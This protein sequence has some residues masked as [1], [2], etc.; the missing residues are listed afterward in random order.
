MKNSPLFEKYRGPGAADWLVT[1]A[2]SALIATEIQTQGA[3]QRAQSGA[4]YY[5]E[6]P[7]VPQLHVG[8]LVIDGLMIA[9]A[10]VWLL[11]PTRK[12][13]RVAMVCVAFVGLSLCW[14]EIM[15]ALHV[16]EGAV[17][18]LDGLPF[19]PVNNGGVIGAQVF[20]T[21]LLLR[22]PAGRLEG[23]RAWAVK[24]ALAVAFWV[25]QFMVWQMVVTR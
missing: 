9:L 6:S 19:Q 2:C 15:Y 14:G 1:L 7:W 23:W 16:Q 18:R 13:A 25:F 3:S 24:S 4:S 8:A 20:G 17:Y 11:T 22:A 5:F 21:Y 12:F 10:M